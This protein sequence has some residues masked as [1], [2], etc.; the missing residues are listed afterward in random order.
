MKAHRKNSSKLISGTLADDPHFII[1]TTSTELVN[2]PQHYGGDST[3]EVIK[4]LEAWGLENDAYL[5]Q[6]VKYIAR[7]GKKDEHVLRDLKKAQFYLNRKIARIEN[8]TDRQGIT[9]FPSSKKTRN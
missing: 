5:F 3:Y 8:G 6:V 2:H 7:S 1:P 4:C 9:R